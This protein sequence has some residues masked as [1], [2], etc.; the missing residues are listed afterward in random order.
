MKNELFVHGTKNETSDRLVSAP[1][2][3]LERLKARAARSGQ[4]GLVLPAPALLQPDTRWSQSNNARAVRDVLDKAG[5]PWAPPH[6]GR[7][8]VASLLEK[9]GVPV[10][11]IADF[12]GHSDQ[13]VTQRYYIG[14]DFGGPKQHLAA[15]L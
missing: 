12:L 13:T 2:W 11:D 8:T 7:R 10:S 5:F 15:L 9:Q 3:L 1:G 6:A 4:V 14:K